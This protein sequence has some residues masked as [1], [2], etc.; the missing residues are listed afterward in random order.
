MTDPAAALAARIAR[1]G[2]FRR[3]FDG[4][5]PVWGADDCSA[6]CARWVAEECGIAPALPSY[7][8]REAAEALIAADPEGLAGL[9]AAAL[10]PV[11]LGETWSPAPGDVGLVRTARFG[12]V[13]MI[14]GVGG[15]AF[16][17]ASGGVTV[18][19]PR[20]ETIVRAWALP[21]PR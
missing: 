21:E 16:W 1:L 14:F 17:R 13:G 8:S 2:E 5:A 12:V 10:V 9:W 11:G 6:F 19:Q 15:L 20:A 7:A 4:S 18:M 3:R